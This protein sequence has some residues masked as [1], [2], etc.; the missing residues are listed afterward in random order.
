MIVVFEV[1]G[2]R[3]YFRFFFRIC[4]FAERLGRLLRDFSFRGSL[5]FYCFYLSDNIFN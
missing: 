3:F 5:A 2:R 1:I 4:N